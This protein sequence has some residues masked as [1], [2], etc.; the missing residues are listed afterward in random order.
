M[1]GIISYSVSFSYT[2]AI[3]GYQCMEVIIF[4]VIET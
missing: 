1:S 2:I 3:L 4:E